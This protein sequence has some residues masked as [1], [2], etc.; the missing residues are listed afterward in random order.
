MMLFQEEGD[1]EQFF[2][3]QHQRCS[4]HTLNL[5][6]TNEVHKAGSNGPSRKLYRSAMAWFIYLEQSTSISTEVIQEIANIIITS[7]TRW[8]SEFRV[9]TKVLGVP[10]DQL[11]NICDKLGVPMP[12]ESAFLKEYTE[13]LQPLAVDIDILQGKNKCYFGIVIPTLLSLK[14]KLSEKLPHVT[15]TAQIITTI[16]KA[17]EHRFGSVLDSH[18]TKMATVT[19]PKFCLSW[20]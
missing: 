2:L 3:P 18:E 6:A 5:I 15:Y 14:A 11:R 20:P 10:E 8:S 9:L 1:E 17:I 13:A 12:M 7:V 4:A 19:L 16:I